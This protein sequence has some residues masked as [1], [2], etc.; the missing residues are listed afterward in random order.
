MPPHDAA[1][2]TPPEPQ[3]LRRRLGDVLVEMGAVAPAQVA[4]A[5]ARQAG[6]DAR[7]GEILRHGG[8]VDAETLDRALARQLGLEH[9]AALPP[10]DGPARRLGE[11]LPAAAALACRAVPVACAD[12]V[13]IVATAAPE[14]LAALRDAL[15]DALLPCRVAI[16]PLALVEVRLAA[17]HGPALAR[18]AEA[19]AP[20]EVSARGRDWARAGGGLALVVVAAVLGL[21]FAPGRAVQA[22][23]LLALAAMTTNL[24]LKALALAAL[25]MPPRRAKPSTAPPGEPAPLPVV[26]ILV[27]LHDEAGILPALIARMARLRYP[28]AL[29]DVLL[30]VEASDA[31]TLRALASCDLPPWMRIVAVP[32]G[33]PRTKPRAMNYALGFAR[34]DVVGVYDAED[35]PE[36][37]QIRA[38][39]DRLAAAPP[40]TACLQGRLDFYNASHNW[41]ARCFAIEYATWFGLLLPGLARMGAVVPLGGTTVFF[42]RAALEAVGAWDAHNVTE[43]ADLG[44]RLSR[45]GFR[46]ELVD[47]T[48]REEANAAARPWIV[49]RSRWLKG[50]AMTWA[51]HSARPLAL[52]RD[53][54]PW[55]FAGF[56]ALFLGS[57][58]GA[59]LLPVAWATVGLGFG[60]PHPVTQGLP[61]WAGPAIGAAMPVLMAVEIVLAWIAC[62]ARGRRHLWPWAPTMQVY[63]PLATFAALRAL[64]ELAIRPFHWDKTSHG[65]FGGRGDGG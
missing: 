39:V 60:M 44:V 22:A 54:G 34:G 15:P 59:L 48:T 56:Q 41:I 2:P 42:R 27:P 13:T 46:V 36:P 62:R 12:G 52:L 24:A 25:A 50:Y 8:A 16:A 38:V 10:L 6:L 9:L 58:L 23:T 4:A 45:A 20:A 57:V 11:A 37:D 5:L 53:L 65:A 3:A 7:L 21:A 40:T 30:V 26:T 29:L 17:L 35:E 43:D 1:P 51:V 55:R 14:R 47:T 61:S 49:Q 19:R 31:P 63:F 28:R 18:A 64:Y 32:D 33:H